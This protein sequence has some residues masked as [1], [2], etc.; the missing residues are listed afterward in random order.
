M[1]NASGASVEA[2]KWL[3]EDRR[4]MTLGA[5][6][7]G[8][9]AMPSQ[10]ASNWLPVHTYLLAQRGTMFIEL[11]YL[12]ELS[13]QGVYEFLFIGA[14]LKLRGAS[15]GPMRPLAIPLR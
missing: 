10:D 9:E 2:I 11:L 3:V 14:P 15:A 5:D 4:G 6:N 8:V 12:E 7:L 13:A 1:R